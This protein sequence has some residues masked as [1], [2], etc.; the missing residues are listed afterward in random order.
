MMTLLKQQL[1]LVQQMVTSWQWD[2]STTPSPPLDT[3]WHTTMERS[4]VPSKI[5]NR[6]RN[7]LTYFLTSAQGPRPG[8]MEQWPLCSTVY[9]RLVVRRLRLHPFDWTAHP[10]QVTNW[11]QTNLLLLRRRE[12]EQYGQLGRS[13]DVASAQL[14]FSSLSLLDYLASGRMFEQIMKDE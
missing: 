7:K 1:R 5:Q 9:W 14:T 11:W 3:P 6:N 2:V 8:C 13:R 10:N 4:S 12:R